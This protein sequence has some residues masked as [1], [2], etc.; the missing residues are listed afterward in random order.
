MKR[1]SSPCIS[2]CHFVGKH[3][4]C[5]GCGR[6]LDEC[7][8]WKH[9]KPYSKKRLLKNLNKRMAIIKR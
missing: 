8:Q 3:K 1:N 7:K 2:D 4:W 9:M 5:Q 6:T